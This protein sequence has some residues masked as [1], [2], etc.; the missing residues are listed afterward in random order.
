MSILSTQFSASDA[1]GAAFNPTGLADDGAM[2]LFMGA[3]VAKANDPMSLL[4]DAAEE[5][6]FSLAESEESKL[7]ERKEKSEKSKVRDSLIHAAQ[8][9]VQH[10][11]EKTDRA[12]N[13][14][15]K[16]CKT[17]NNVEL[18]ELLQTLNQ[19]LAEPSGQREGESGLPDSADRFIVLTGL[20]DRLGDAHPLAATIDAALR[21]LAAEETSAIA[22][23]LAV[24]LA[25]PDFPALREEQNLRGIYR[26]VV[27]DFASPRD[28]LT[29]LMTQFGQNRLDEGLN[30]LM[31]VLGNELSSVAPSAEKSHLKALTGD[32]ATVRVLGI[33]QDR[34]AVLLKRLDTAHGVPGLLGPEALLDK[35]LT[36]R[37][38]QYLGAHDFATLTNQ[39]GLPDTERKVLFQQDVMQGLRD[40]PGLFYGDDATR[41]RMLDAA[42]G[43]LDESIRLEEEELGY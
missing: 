1:V 25:A 21:T 40:F 22:S 16:L 39:L 31:T 42:Q 17:R 37:D 12:L 9:A 18:A 13:H 10:L 4:A 6:T 19:D 43:S 8:K 24:E 7:D 15:E 5:L 27:A 41:V 32:L 30:F 23:G 34:C 20:K 29:R 35:F 36:M 28:A 14:L 3:E 11:D 2:G 33:V 26:S 38:N